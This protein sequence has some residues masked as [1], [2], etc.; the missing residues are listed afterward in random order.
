MKENLWSIILRNT[1][2]GKG[3][4]SW[5][6][7]TWC[8]TPLTSYEIYFGNKRWNDNLQNT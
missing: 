7:E 1:I 5:K 8:N 2:F 6:Y 3:L 4:N